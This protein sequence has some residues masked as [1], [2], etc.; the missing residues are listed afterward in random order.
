MRMAACLLALA[1]VCVAMSGC[2]GIVLSAPVIPPPGFV[3]TS[4]TA[5]LDVDFD[6]SQIADSR[7]GE[8]GIVNILG[9]VCIG[10]AGSMD[11]AREGNLSRVDGADY[12]ML[13]VLG[14]FSRYGTVVYGQ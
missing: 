8:S 4:Y 14:V 7:K 11:A 9:I 1:L 10:D 3:F 13:S 2:A 12:T 5:P 6:R